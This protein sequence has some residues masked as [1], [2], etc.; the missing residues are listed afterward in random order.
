MNI[1]T[2]LQRKAPAAITVDILGTLKAAAKLLLRHRI[3][4]LVVTEADLPVG[5]LT[6]GHIVEALAHEGRLAE[7]LRVRQVITR[8]LIAVSPEDTIKRAMS[9][10]AQ[11]KISHLPVVQEKKLLGLVSLG[12]MVKHCF[13]ELELESLDI[14]ATG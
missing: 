3:G 7:E 14:D 8:Q 6:K 5:L 12:D 11:F 2:M 10:M 1:G 9:L 13:E 4:A